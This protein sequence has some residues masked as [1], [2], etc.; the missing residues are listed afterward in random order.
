M[1]KKGMIGA[2]VFVILAFA[3]GVVTVLLYM[4]ANVT[5]DEL[6]ANAPSLQESLSS[7]VS[8]VM[9]DTFGR[10][11]SALESLKWITV[12]LLI[13]MALATILAAFFVRVHKIFLVLY[14]LFVIVAVIISVPLSNTYEDLTEQADLAPYF[15]GFVGQNFIFEYLPYW[16]TIIGMFSGIIMFINMMKDSG[17]E[18]GG[19]GFGY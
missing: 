1:N 12:M 16:V 13:G 5:A 8:E 14:V 11:V 6:Y 3:V 17:F 15:E 2:I 10:Y 4:I 9:H 19:G 18:G 7:N